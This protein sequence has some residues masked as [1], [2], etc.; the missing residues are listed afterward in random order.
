MNGATSNLALACLENGRLSKLPGPATAMAARKFQVGLHVQPNR[1][2][3]KQE[4]IITAIADLS[5]PLILSPTFTLPSKKENRH[6][7]PENCLRFQ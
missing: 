5:H 2:D 4:A 6:R 7:I 3:N 1:E